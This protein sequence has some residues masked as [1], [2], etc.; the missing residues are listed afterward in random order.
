MSHRD[1]RRSRKLRVERLE[2]R[3]MLTGDLELV[4]DIN[5]G[6]DSSNPQSLTLVGDTVYFRSYNALG[7]SDG[8]SEGT[9][10]VKVLPPSSSGS[11]TQWKLMNVGGT[12]YFTVPIDVYDHE[13]WKSDGTEAGTVRIAPTVRLNSRSP[14]QS[15]GVDNSSF[16]TEVGGVLYFSGVEAGND[17]ELW[18]SDGTTTGTYRVKDI[19][20]GS[21]SSM[22]N[23]FV[24]VNNALYFS[25][26]DGASNFELWRSD[27][28]EAG[29]VRVKDAA[30]GSAVSYPHNLT[31]VSGTLY[32]STRDFFSTSF[33]L[34]KS[35]GTEA[36]TELVR[37]FHRSPKYL[38][39]IN[40][41]LYFS[42]MAFSAPSQL[43]KS[44][45]T[46]AGTVQVGTVPN[47]GPH[48]LTN[49]DGALYF[50][51][52]GGELWRSDGSAAGTIRIKDIRP[53]FSDSKLSLMTNVAGR[54]YFRAN[55]GT[56]GEELW[57]SDGTAAGTAPVRLAV[58]GPLR[59]PAGI[60]PFGSQ[61]V[62]SG[63]Q[64]EVGAELFSRQFVVNEVFPPIGDYDLNGV[65]NTADRDFWLTYFGATTG[66]GLQADGNANGIVDTADYTIWRDA[67]PTPTATT[68]T[69]AIASAAVSA[70]APQ[71]IAASP[72]RREGHAAAQ[73]EELPP[74]NR[75][76]HEAQLLLAREEAFAE[77]G[78][79][80]TPPDSTGVRERAPQRGVKSAGV[81]SLRDADFLPTHKKNG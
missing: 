38:T 27:G 62:V 54:L 34:W 49:I 42:G 47:S 31:N 56:T 65:V 45:G 19:R 58:G 77:W 63:A 2:S 60:I 80:E 74:L 24:N 57:R 37:G 52:A 22:P 12:L 33:G 21:A 17:L 72:V 46:T 41:V 15:L 48:G 16:I 29:T 81:K 14:G 35:Y 36:G 64:P 26:N 66:I 70:I 61:L 30:P 79:E 28:T 23:N 55:D 69:V 76:A 53:Q 7:K 8:T 40:G 67:L 75:G 68:S 10:L 6:T 4:K 5:P 71:P 78:A 50:G 39:N 20:P 51:A 18:R 25:A 1:D 3:E 59:D 44:D 13:L 32:Y 43:W 11:L 9:S 73:R